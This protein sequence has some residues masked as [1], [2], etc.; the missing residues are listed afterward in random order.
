MICLGSQALG[1]GFKSTLL[2]P[3]S[4]G[5]HFSLQGDMKITFLGDQI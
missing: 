5:D 3:K 1:E 4:H 2:S